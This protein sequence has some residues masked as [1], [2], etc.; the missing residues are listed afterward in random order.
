[1]DGAVALVLHGIGSQERERA[2]ARVC[3]L[4]EQLGDTASLLRGFINLAIVY[5]RGEPQRAREMAR[6]YLASAEQAGEVEMLAPAH[7]IAAHSSHFCGD[8]IEAVSK[9]RELMARYETVPQG[10]FPINVWALVPGTCCSALHLLGRI[11]EALKLGQGSLVRA[12]EVKQPFSLGMA[13]VL[14][15]WL[16]QLRREP[17]VVREVAESAMAL[18]DEYGFPEWQAWGQWLHGWAIT[19]LGDSKRG[20]SE[21]EAGIAEFLPIGGVPRYAFTVAM[22]AKGYSEVGRV[23]EGLA[24]LDEMLAR[25]EHSGERLDEAELR[26]VE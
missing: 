26:R 24:L 17:E 19:E 22:L 1:V 20:L 14:V 13:L 7:W 3:E 25:I 11:S 2:F 5:T 21:M 23:D 16:H 8:L 18:G 4:S 6:R 9:Y 12:R 10:G 15:A